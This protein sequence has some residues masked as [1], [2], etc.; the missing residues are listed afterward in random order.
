[1]RILKRIER[2]KPLCGNGA[3]PSVV[4]TEDA[5]TRSVVPRTD[6]PPP[7]NWVVVEEVRGP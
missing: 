7:R 6:R 1:M 2:P 4:G 3:P 5:L